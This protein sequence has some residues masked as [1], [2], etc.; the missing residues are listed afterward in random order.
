MVENEKIKTDSNLNDAYCFFRIWVAGIHPRLCSV[1]PGTPLARVERPELAI[2]CRQFLRFWKSL[3]KLIPRCHNSF[4]LLADRKL[5]KT[6]RRKIFLF[7]A[8]KPLRR[9]FST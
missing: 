7:A 8:N 1:F 3:R 4:I 5:M 9:E 2:L 6:I